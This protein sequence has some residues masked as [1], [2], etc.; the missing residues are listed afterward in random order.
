MKI[1]IE[2]DDE[3]YNE[4]NALFSARGVQRERMGLPIDTIE[5]R[6][7]QYIDD[8]YA[9]YYRNC[10]VVIAPKATV[11]ITPERRAKMI[12]AI[13]KVEAVAVPI[14]EKPI[15]ELRVI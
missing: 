14:E 13:D 7:N 12:E 6:L 5:R 10:A 11:E 8:M 4:L 1:I 15:E 2:M 9:A 3:K